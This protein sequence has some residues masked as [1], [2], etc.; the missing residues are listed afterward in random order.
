VCGIAGEL[1]FGAPVDAAGVEAMS[2]AIS[3][4]GPDDEGLYC[5]GTVG[6]A[7][8]RL[9]IIDLSSAGKNPIW[10]ED[11]SMAIIFNGE[12]Y[13]Y[14]DVRKALGAEG[15]TFST[16]TDTEVVLKAVRH[17]GMAGALPRLIGM[18]AFAIWN[19]AERS[20]SLARDRVGV[21]PLFYARLRDRVIFGSELK[22][23]YAH[24]Q[25]TQRLN[26]AA[27]AQFFVLGYTVGEVTP[28]EDT[29]RVPAGHFLTIGP[30]GRTT[31]ERYWSLD[32]V[33]RGSYRGSFEDAAAD[34]Q[35]IAQDA[36][37]HRLV[38]DVPV[39]VFLSGGIDST[40]LTAILKH[41]LG[42]DLL[43]LTIGFG[44]S[45]YDEAPMAQDIA[46]QL[47][48]RHKVS[49]VEAPEA[50]DA[51]RRFQSIYDEPFGDTSG[52]PTAIVS[53]IARADAK[54]AL[55]AD[56]GDEQFCGY[57]SYATYARRYADAGRIPGALRRLA[58]G[59]IAMLPY[60]AAISAYS[61]ARGHAGSPRLSSTLEKGLE[62]MRAASAGDVARIMNEKGWPA[63]RAAAV[64]GAT[65]DDV[66]GGTIFARQLVGLT[67]G[68]DS[69]IVDHMMRTDFQTFMRDD[70]L[71]K[72]DRAS[73]AVSLEVRDPFV[74]H[75]IAEFAF[76]LPLEYHYAN[77]QHKRLLKHV[78]REWVDDRVLSA[79]K[80]GF[81]I[82]LYEWMRGPWRPLVDE[83]LTPERVRAVGILDEAIVAAEV[84]RFYRY[85]GVGAERL[86][87]LLNFQMW[88][89]RWYRP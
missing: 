7:H 80:R 34:L 58:A 87:L 28:F 2:R 51:L 33:E 47:G 14:A 63:A 64:V 48:V 57:E 84:D 41:R 71:A 36:F 88:A 67:G 26:R 44:Q 68:G 81:V 76:S 49:Y 78:L 43:H 5:E 40:F 52:I 13:N 35:T 27:L 60:H 79:P 25:Y 38:S 89:E 56:G 37:A 30:D 74:D 85:R 16:A 21:K 20:L 53:T 18:F 3:H 66:F 82:P 32:H 69:A 50:A 19:P 83:Y 55:S 9:A 70:V 42:A 31:L 1:T 65:V 12:V 17:W 22:A 6:L 23:L 75:R 45:R 86:Q 24:P 4:R 10:T 15:V 72:V 77:G 11:R 46:R 62:V 39:A 73:M 59:E 29:Y 61:A 54:V 8:R